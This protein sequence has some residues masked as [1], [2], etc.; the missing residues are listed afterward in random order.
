MRCVGG[1]RGAAGWSGGAARV[2]ALSAMYDPCARRRVDARA[3]LEVSRSAPVRRDLLSCVDVITF[4]SPS[5]NDVFLLFDQARCRL[6]GESRHARPTRPT[7]KLISRRALRFSRSRLCAT[8]TDPTGPHRC[9]RFKFDKSRRSGSS[10][11]FRGA[12]EKTFRHGHGGAHRRE[13]RRR[14]RLVPRAER[15]A[16]AMPRA[17]LPTR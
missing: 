13:L 17:R 8:P 7:H 1:T 15:P 2:M 10:A 5:A 16:R 14:A 12:R 4:V 11:T 3:P 6:A 9:K